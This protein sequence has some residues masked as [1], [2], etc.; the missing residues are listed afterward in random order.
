MEDIRN[1]NNLYSESKKRVI[2][3]IRHLLTKET[4]VNKN[5]SQ[6]GMICIV[7][8]KGTLQFENGEKLSLVTN[9][10]FMYDKD[11][12][13]SLTFDGQTEVFIL[14]F[15]FKCNISCCGFFKEP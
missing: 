12:E 15:N 2:I 5:L 4:Y 9:D 3:T 8:G 11:R 7:D 10:C 13:F 6:A 14:H 1:I